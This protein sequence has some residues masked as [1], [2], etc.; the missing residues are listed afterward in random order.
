MGRRF[1][2]GER[3]S[4]MLTAQPD[5]KPKPRQYTAS[6]HQ[7]GER[8]IEVVGPRV[9]TGVWQCRRPSALSIFHTWT[10]G[11]E[12]RVCQS[13]IRRSG[14]QILVCPT[15]GRVQ[16]AMGDS[17]GLPSSV[18]RGVPTRQRS[19]RSLSSFFVGYVH[20]EPGVAQYESKPDT[21]VPIRDQ[22]RRP[23]Q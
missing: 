5:R 20:A 6:C 19:G 22:V 23:P 3:S 9:M 13:R 12:M 10:S 16:P 8:F 21:S 7:R 18:T 4:W 14:L 11:L 2:S 1:I 15:A 17:P